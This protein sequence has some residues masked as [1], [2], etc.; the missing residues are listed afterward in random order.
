[1]QKSKSPKPISQRSRGETLKQMESTSQLEPG[2]HGSPPA[3]SVTPK[4]SE[5]VC[6]RK[7]V[8]VI[9]GPNHSVALWTKFIASRVKRLELCAL[10]QNWFSTGATES[11]DKLLREKSCVSLQTTLRPLH[12]STTN[13]RER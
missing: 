5:S 1:M 2:K 11:L 7:I 6:G 10:L 12:S 9:Q 3:S 13:H 8:F 4:V